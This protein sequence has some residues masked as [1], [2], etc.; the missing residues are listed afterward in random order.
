MNA[1]LLVQFVVQRAKNE[2]AGMDYPDILPEHLLLG[3]LKA[4]Q[5]QAEDITDDEEEKESVQREIENLAGE[6]A[7]KLPKQRDI[8]EQRGLIRRILL[9]L[10]DMGEPKLTARITWR[11]QRSARKMGKEEVEAGDLFEALQDVPTKLLKKYYPELYMKN[12]EP[13]EKETE[14]LDLKENNGRKDRG[15]SLRVQGLA[16]LSAKIRAMETYLLERVKGQDEAVLAFCRGI[17]SSFIFSAGEETK[18]K[19]KGIF[20]FAGPPGVG[21]TFLAELAAGPLGLPLFRLDMSEY[22]Y[23]DAVEELTGFDSTFKNSKEGYLTKFV[24]DNPR[25]ILLFDEIEKTHSSVINLFLQLLDA[26]RLTDRFLKKVVS[27]EETIIIFTTNAG[28]SIYEKEGKRNGRVSAEVLL[29]ALRTEKNPQ[30]NEPAFPAAICSRL[31]TGYPV[32][33]KSLTAADLIEIAYGELLRR[34]KQFQESYGLPVK[35]DPMVPAL[36][37]LGRGGDTDARSLR[38]EAERFF[39]EE[40]FRLSQYFDEQNFAET[41]ASAGC[42]A[43]APSEKTGLAELDGL[44]KAGK[45]PILIVGDG[46]TVEFCQEILKD[47]YQICGTDS[48]WEAGQMLERTDFLFVLAQL[49]ER[50]DEMETTVRNLDHVPVTASYLRRFTEFLEKAGEERPEM[51]VFAVSLSEEGE[52]RQLEAALI[53]KGIRS[54]I[55]LERNGEQELE[56]LKDLYRQLA[57][58]QL[59]RRFAKEHLKLE[60]ETAPLVKNGKIQIRMRNFRISR[61]ISGEDSDSVLTGASVPDVCFDDIIGAEDVKR[62]MRW[63]ISFIKDPRKY[64]ESGLRIPR[65]IL[66][67]GPPGTGKTYLAKALAHEAGVP[68][69]QANGSDFV[70]IYAG[71]GPMTVKKLFERARRYAPSIIFIDE[72]DAIGKERTGNDSNQSREETLNKLLS[73]MDGFLSDKRPPVFVVAATNFPVVKEQPGQV[74]LDPALVRRFDRKILVELPSTKDREEYLIR[75]LADMDCT[76]SDEMITSIAARSVGL[77]FAVLKN[78]VEMAGRLALDAGKPLDDAILDEAFER[79]RFGEKREGIQDDPETLLRVARHEAGHACI[80]WLCGRK[81]SY[82]T[83]VA[84]GDHGGYV[85]PEQQRKSFYTRKEL[86]GQIRT[87][88]AGRGAEILYYGPEDGITTTAS[89]DLQNASRVAAFLVCRLGMDEKSG[90]AVFGDGRSMD[91]VQRKR[92]EEI[93]SE[94]M[95]QVL[96]LLADNKERLDALAAALMEKNKL[97]TEEIVEIMEGTNT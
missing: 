45:E 38:A 19:P 58:Q 65:G 39:K 83:I 88:L 13:E 36:L 53:Q 43:F 61:R 14:D 86:K 77:S 22:V 71:S 89:S 17:A 48:W 94:E 1:S 42:I 21:K 81:P 92:I 18:K 54:F 33:F 82:I 96:K 62:E 27:F 41:L 75:L 68:F 72:I 56:K 49:P 87:S 12:G 24:M 37:L 97:K 85:Q 5:L 63:F 52:D 93:L 60:F 57:L 31:A 76:V 67:Y 40:I 26:G 35:I 84:R 23:R 2:A 10:R 69:L 51:S 74:A 46:E 66:L 20:L 95:E 64:K 4:S 3:L 73:E 7:K 34:G 15:A 80:S 70:G 32:L 28:H 9:A 8:A 78:I 50:E 79:D 25:C 47:T 59:A 30:T 16:E 90:L 6:V 11:A 44:K 91:M 29:N 55:Y